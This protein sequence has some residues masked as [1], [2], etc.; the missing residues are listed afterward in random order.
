[1][2]AMIIQ[3]GGARNFYLVL[4]RG[5]E[6]CYIRA[7]LAAGDN[8]SWSRRD[9][10]LLAA[11]AAW[12]VA[13]R[14]AFLALASG[15]PLFHTPIMDMS[16]HDAWARRIA[17]GDFWGS[18]AF[19]RAPLYPYFLGLLYWLGHGSTLLAR[20]VQG[21]VG[22]VSAALCFVLAREL[23]D[24]RVGA[25]AAFALGTIWTAVYFDVELLL[26]VLEVPLGLAFI[27][28]TVRAIKSLKPAW[29]AAAGLA[30]GL[31]AITR[32]NVLA[33]GVVIWLAFVAWHRRRSVEGLRKT[34]WRRILA[35]LAVLYG[36]AAAFVVATAV[37]NYVVAGEPI[38]V[39]WQGG[40]NLW[41]GNNPDADGMTAIAPGTYGDWWRGHYETIRMAEEAAG[42]TLSRAEIDHYYFGRTLAFARDDP[43]AALKLLARK[44]YVYTNAYE[45]ANNF[46]LYYMKN[47]FWILK[48]DP[49]SLYVVLPLAFFGAIAWA[50]RWR[51]LAPLYLFVIFYSASVV[52]FFV[53]ARFRMPVVPYFCIFA[54]AAF[55]YL[56][57]NVRNWRGRGLVWRVVALAAL[58]GY[59]DADPF[60]VANRSSYE[61]QAHYTMGSIYLTQ[62]NLD[63]AE[64]EYLAALEVFPSTSG[65]DALN[66]LGI[67]A[68]QRGDYTL[69][70]DYFRR[71]I[72]YKPDYSKGYNNLGNLALEA[73]DVAGARRYYERALEVDPADARAY[74]FY[75]RLLL[76]E[77]DAEGAAA[78]FGRAVYYQP[79]FTAAW[80]ELGKLARAAGDLARA[81]ECYEE[82]LYF[83]PDS[84]EAR[85]ALADV[86]YARGDF[87]GAAREYRAA[88][89]TADD[90]RSHYNL[91]CALARLGRG[92]EAMA[93]LARAVELAPGRYQP[94]AAGDPD[95]ASLRG[96]PDFERLVAR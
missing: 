10:A 18:E 23:F 21:C 75:G 36:V 85:A 20:I 60:G 79:N 40:V 81:Q 95:L 52:L 96:R 38:A 41:I 14:L 44:A 72:A 31:G 62:G 67:I 57:D 19:F 63:A 92:D 74:Y 94:M 8:E 89:A 70:A 11:V 27:Y 22:G 93:E 16:Y 61:S 82:A 78:K 28:F 69:A 9:W 26:V 90:P 80:Y 33:V 24:R 43:G 15:H 53:N 50:R 59:C 83:L 17:G 68:A 7:M 91:A 1:M 13:L 66:D 5:G 45:V 6:R 37:R 34:P 4:R 48:Y 46:D 77:G 58:F 39:S 3:N 49:V 35:T 25:L 12:A 51:R 73:G 2:F 30:L 56:W 32:P 47:K 87:A 64:E 71:S 55:Y 42:R 88:L 86:L 76:A 54:A 65:A 84:W 29:G